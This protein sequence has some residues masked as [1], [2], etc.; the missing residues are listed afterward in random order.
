MAGSAKH[1]WEFWSRTLQMD[2]LVLLTHRISLP[3]P[4][5]MFPSCVY[6]RQSNRKKKRPNLQ[7]S[8]LKIIKLFGLEDF[9]LSLSC[10]QT[11]QVLLLTLESA[12]VTTP[13]TITLACDFMT[14]ETL[15][16]ACLCCPLVGF[17]HELS[18]FSHPR[19]LSLHLSNPALGKEQ[20]ARW[21]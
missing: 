12:S 16:L 6:L 14:G 5:F 18:S 19:T 15:L 8:G 9:L 13:P 21:G 11:H 2:A 20:A 10:P 3:A 7:E 17:S 4:P 1:N